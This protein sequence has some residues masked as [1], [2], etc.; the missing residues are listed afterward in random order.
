MP[1]EVYLAKLVT[2]N[3]T[4]IQLKKEDDN[5]TNNVVWK[6]KRPTQIDAANH[7]W[8]QQFHIWSGYGENNF[9]S[10]FDS[11]CITYADDIT[12]HSQKRAMSGQQPHNLAY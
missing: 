9:G 11:Q 7:L 10:F 8:S 6:T 3:V 12:D 2:D 4:C 1:I 5:T